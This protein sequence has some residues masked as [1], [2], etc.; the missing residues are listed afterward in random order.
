MF[1]SVEGIF[2]PVEPALSPLLSDLGIGD[3]WVLAASLFC[4]L[5]FVFFIVFLVVNARRRHWKRAARAL[6]EDIDGLRQ[7][8]DMGLQPLSGTLET[9]GDSI[10]FQPV[11]GSRAV[12]GSSVAFKMP[13]GTESCG[14][15]GADAEPPAAVCAGSSDACTVLASRP[16]TGDASSV[17][18]ISISSVD[19]VPVS[20][21]D[22]FAESA[23]RSAAPATQ[24]PDATAPMAA[25]AASPQALPCSDDRMERMGRTASFHIGTHSVI[26]VPCVEERGLPQAVQDSQDRC[27]GTPFATASLPLSEIS[28]KIP[29]V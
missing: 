13:S 19:G 26:P 2:Q 15:P 28:S 7:A 16:D 6:R 14:Q 8:G 10:V 12:A 27:P 18:G 4:L 25:P 5:F 23:Y 20:Q 17:A 29:R 21:V 9:A 3:V 1:S 11:G 24:L 22:V